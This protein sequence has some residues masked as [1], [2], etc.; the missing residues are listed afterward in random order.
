MRTL[1]RQGRVTIV[2]LAVALA[3]AGATGGCGGRY[4]T[5]DVSDEERAQIRSALEEY[6]RSA[7]EKA[8]RGE[9]GVPKWLA[10]V[11]E[12][13][14]VRAERMDEGYRALARLKGPRSTARHFLLEEKDGELTVTGVLR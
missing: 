7:A 8:R 1:I 3:V 11:E 6:V 13:D 2:L 12:V 10:E 9:S 4:S 5:A 14:L